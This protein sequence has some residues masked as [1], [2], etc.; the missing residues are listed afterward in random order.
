MNAASAC[1]SSIFLIIHSKI[2]F[3]AK[4]HQGLFGQFSGKIG[5]VVGYVLNGQQCVRGHVIPKQTNSEKANANRSKFS[6]AVRFTC[7]MK[8]ALPVLYPGYKS[9]SLWNQA[10]RNI[11]KTGFIGEDSNL[12]IDYS[13]V[14]ISS[15]R[16]QG[17]VTAKAKGRYGDIAVTWSRSKDINGEKPGN[18]VILI[19]YCEALNKCIVSK[20]KIDSRARTAAF[21][22]PDFKRAEVH[23]W[24]AFTGTN[25]MQA[26][27]CTYAGSV[28]VL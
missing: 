25:E 12:T 18:K 3:M 21:A 19:A 28:T 9:S 26:L 24:L 2:N 13:N 11:L 20:V 10:L 8:V 14:T 7:G 17:A 23:T 6:M 22:V 27:N 5:N 16:I 4:L 15:C 1:G